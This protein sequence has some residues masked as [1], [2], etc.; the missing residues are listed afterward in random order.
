MFVI[1]SNEQ[2]DLPIDTSLIEEIV[3]QFLKEERIKTDEVYINLVD[4]PTICRL[5][6]DYFGDPSS[7]DCISFPMDLDVEDEYAILGEVFVCPA[8]AILYALEHQLDPYEET[9]LY[10]VHGLLHLIGYDDI[11]EHDR[12]EMLMA[13]MRHMDKLKKKELVLRKKD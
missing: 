9:T 1:V 6:Q 7:T 13:E 11:K 3:F 8:T 4:T 10:I 2:K 12:Q 5:H